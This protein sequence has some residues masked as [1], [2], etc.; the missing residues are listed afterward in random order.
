MA[1]TTTN[2]STSPIIRFY[3][4]TLQ[5]PDSEGRT[6]SSVLAWDDHKLE[7]CHNYIQWL[8]PLPERSSMSYSAPVVSRSTFH[9]FRTRPELRDR[10]R[11]SSKRICRFYGFDFQASNEFEGVRIERLQDRDISRATNW[12]S[13]FT[14]NHLRITRIIRSLRVLGL[15]D[16]ATAFFRAVE[17]VYNT[18]GRIGA[19]SLMYWTRAVERPLYLAP[20]DEEDGG[21]GKDFLYEFEAEKDRNTKELKKAKVS[22]LAQ[23]SG[24]VEEQESSPETPN[25]APMSAGGIAG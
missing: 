17:D 14:H 1:K 20:E 15:E 6:L 25:G 3:D 22:G 4:P 13:G 5:A 23:E 9:A 2:P 24:G 12:V 7:G 10:M 21:N 16:E 18:T 8:F 11:D 19:R